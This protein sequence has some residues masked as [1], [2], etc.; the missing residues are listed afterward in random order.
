MGIRTVEQYK[1]SLRDGR[2]VYIR[3]QKVDDVTAHPILGVTVDTVAMGFELTAST[4][5]E[6]RDLFTAPHP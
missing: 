2:R 6:V 4:D 1:E 5:P 3:G